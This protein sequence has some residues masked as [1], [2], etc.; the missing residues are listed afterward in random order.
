MT[1]PDPH[2][3][4]PEIA[5]A[6]ATSGGHLSIGR[7]GATL[8]YCNSRL[9]GCDCATIKAAAI[10]AGL[11]V[12]DSRM[13]PFGLAARLAV[14]GPMVAVNE[15]PSPRPWHAFSYAPLA[16]VAAAY[17]QA[18]AEVVNLP[19]EPALD[20]LFERLPAGPEADLIA[21]WLKHVCTH[22]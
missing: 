10:A 21:F 12:I 8:H 14:E 18:G 5:L 13:V 22:G 19:A 4:Q 3:Y 16:V 2:D 11:P 6:L 9:S 17:R 15:P 1:P 7:G 20:G